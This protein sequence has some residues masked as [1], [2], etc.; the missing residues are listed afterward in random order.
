[1]TRE[2]IDRDREVPERVH[3]R[4]RARAA[5]AGQSLSEYLLAEITGIADRPSNSDVLARAAQRS[6]GTTLKKI[7]AAVRSGRGR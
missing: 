7:A 1:L 4:L 2:Q 6:G 3:K 5:A